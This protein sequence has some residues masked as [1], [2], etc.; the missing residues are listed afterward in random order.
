MIVLFVCLLTARQT[1]HARYTKVMVPA[2]ESHV[3]KK[4]KK[5]VIIYAGDSR[6]MM[7][8]YGSAGKARSR[9]AFCW[10]NG[11]GV[12]VINKGGSLES[13]LAAMIARYRDNCVVI[14]NFGVNGNSNPEK[15]ARRIIRIYR[16][17]MKKYPDVSFYVMSLNP[18]GHTRGSYSNQKIKRT[19]AVLKEAFE[20][21]GQY[22]DC[23]S[24]LLEKD[25]VSTGGKG[26]MDN[27][28]YRPFVCRAIMKFVKKSLAAAGS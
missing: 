18:S 22:L 1:A 25:I 16:R 2:S 5:Q 27:L 14:L 6:T 7:L 4:G 24:Y 10:V 11:G 17:W 8:T 12:S 20:G 19:N 15:N 28:H 3:S 13:R 9:S 26:M 21:T 23:Y